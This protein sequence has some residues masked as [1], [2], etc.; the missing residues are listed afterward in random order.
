MV[1]AMIWYNIT[2]HFVPP[3]AVF[4]WPSPLMMCVTYPGL[5]PTG[6]DW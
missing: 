6:F 1:D 3:F 5:D 2:I 4:V